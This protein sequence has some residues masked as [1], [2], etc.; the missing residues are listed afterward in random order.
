MACA[1]FYRDHKGQRQVCRG[2]KLRQWFG[3]A[4]SLVIHLSVL[5]LC[6]QQTSVAGVPAASADSDT[7]KRMEVALVSATPSIAEHAQSIAGKPGFEKPSPIPLSAPRRMMEK[8]TN[9]QPTTPALPIFYG[10]QDVE[11]SALPYSAPDPDL[12]AGVVASGLPIRVRLYI[13]AN[14]V[15]T[16]VEKLQALADDQQAFERIERMLRGTAFMPAKLAGNDVN[17]YQDLEF[18]IGPEL[19]KTGVVE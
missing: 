14:G 19:N 17:S 16:G 7:G 5:A 11:K 9:T 18:F 8:A 4:A 13:D 2:M 10:P 12:L 6:R 3:V 15:V 1:V